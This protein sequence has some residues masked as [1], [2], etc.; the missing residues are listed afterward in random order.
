M[1][2]A[3]N[4]MVMAHDDTGGDGRLMVLLPGAGDVR[5][6]HRFLAAR[7]AGQG[8]RVVT[9]DLPGHGQS[10]IASE[11]TLASTAAAIIDLVESIQAGPALV[12]ACSFAPAAAVWAAAERPE[13]LSGIVAISPHLHADDSVKGKAQEVL[14]NA[15]MRGPWAVGQRARL[16]GAGTSPTRRPISVSRWPRCA[17]CSP[18]R[19]DVPPPVRPSRPPARGSPP[20]SSDWACPP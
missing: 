2:A 4:S 5:S 7:L 1:G 10:Q 13:L 17:P 9:A 12:V 11:Y 19:T 20:G 8:F 15:L 3:T 18:T 16:T 14:L 6:E